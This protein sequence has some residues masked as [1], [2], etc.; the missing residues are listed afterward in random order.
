M[1][2]QALKAAVERVTRDAPMLIENY[3]EGDD[4]NR[5]GRDLRLLLTAL[6][7]Q[8]EVMEA[9]AGLLSQVAGDGPL[10]FMIGGN[11]HAIEDFNASVTDTLTQYR[12]LGGE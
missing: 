9:M 12:S 7:S 8:A 2:D 10:D 3:C 5:L 4:R 6:S 11:P 1:T